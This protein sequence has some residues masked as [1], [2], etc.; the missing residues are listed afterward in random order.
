MNFTKKN[1]LTISLIGVI[2]FTLYSTYS[3]F[4]SEQEFN[5]IKIIGYLLGFSIYL[6]LILFLLIN[7][8]KEVKNEK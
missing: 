8:K 5:T 1:K 6:F 7:I 2:L 3:I 4:G